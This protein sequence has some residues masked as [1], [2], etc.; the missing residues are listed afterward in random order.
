MGEIPAVAFRESVVLHGKV[1]RVSDGDTIRVRHTPLFPLIGNT[2]DTGRLT[3]ETLIIRLMGVDA[4]EVAKAG[5]A[6][7]PFSQESKQFVMNKVLNQQV[8][9]KL[10]SRDQYA[11]A[12]CSISYSP[13]SSWKWFPFF[14][15]D[16]SEELLK[17]GLAV[18]YR[19][20]GGQ[21]D[22]RLHKM[23]GLEA[24][25]KSKR[26]GVWSKKGAELP[27]EYKARA[28]RE[29][30]DKILGGVGAGAGG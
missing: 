29:E 1:V 27:H 17:E 22:G 6:G 10:L 11:R 19:Q 5:G 18:I 30:M 12:V 23:E 24:E 20:K 4:P 7:Q 15:K 8:Q 28:K 26:K 16:L 25:A 13:F 14:R 3:E 21:Y 2:P 9:V